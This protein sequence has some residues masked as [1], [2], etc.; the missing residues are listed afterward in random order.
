MI[1]IVYLPL[2]IAIG[3]N[4]TLSKQLYL[5]YFPVIQLQNH[6]FSSLLKCCLLHNSHASKY[7]CMS[8]YSLSTRPARHAT[9]TVKPAHK[10]GIGLFSV[11]VYVDNAL[12][13]FLF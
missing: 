12:A 8:T 6:V 5:V 2:C 11:V 9:L 4:P 10:A 3:K 7:T 13:T 1:F